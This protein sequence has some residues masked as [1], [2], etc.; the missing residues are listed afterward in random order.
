LAELGYYSIAATLLDVAL[1]VPNA[2][3]SVL[4]S[5]FTRVESSPK[6][7][8]HTLLGLLAIVSGCAVFGA[9]TAP[10]LLPLVFGAG[11]V[12]SVEPFRI[13]LVALI[14]QAPLAVYTGHLTARAHAWGLLLP[15]L[16]SLLATSGAAFML[17][18]AHGMNGA[19]WAAVVGYAVQLLTTLPFCF[20]SPLK[21]E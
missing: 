3:T 20:K 14:L 21:S 8:R 7:R 10:Y 13:L 16:A 2:V 17:I 5:H 6:A 12:A 18:P 15:P 9:I 19:A 1:M 4:I 11:F